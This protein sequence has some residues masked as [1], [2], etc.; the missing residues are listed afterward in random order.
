MSG[1]DGAGLFI[2]GLSEREKVEALA[3]LAAYEPEAFTRMRA[4]MEQRKNQE[5]AGE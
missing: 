2:G 1:T 5:P 3:W 4:E